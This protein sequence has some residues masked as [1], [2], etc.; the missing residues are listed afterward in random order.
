MSSGSQAQIA[1]SQA[2][3]E[4]QAE[5]ARNALAFS[6]E[7]FQAMQALRKPYTD[8]G[9]SATQMLS[10]LLGLQPG[11]VNNGGGGGTSLV[12]TGGGTGS[13]ASLGSAGTA[14]RTG[15]TNTGAGTTGT[16]PP[17]FTGEKFPNNPPAPY[18]VG[19]IGKEKPVPGDQPPINEGDPNWVAGGAPP[20]GAPPWGPTWAG[21]PPGK[22]AGTSFVTDPA[23]GKTFTVPSNLTSLYA[24]KGFKV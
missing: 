24:A 23:T 10:N 20:P 12:Q 3:T 6:K 4:A 7:Q 5:A 16:T 13:L 19:P 11:L 18:Q 9:A 17:P 8:I 15:G 22:T 2:A 21:V 1:A 14:G